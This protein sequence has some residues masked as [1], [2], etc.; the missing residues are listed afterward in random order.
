LDL[1][2]DL[3][4]Q[5][6]VHHL[7]LIGAYRDNEVDP[8]HPLIRKLEAIRMA[9]AVVHEVVLTPLPREALELLIRDALYCESEQA[10]ALASLIHEKT[11][12]NP[13]FA[14]QLITVLVE[15]ALLKFDYDEGQWSWDLDRIRAKGYTDNVVDLMVA[16]L[17]RLPAETQQALQLL[18]CMG[19]SAD[20]SLLEMA[21]RQ[22]IEEMHGPLWEAVR[23]GL[24]FRSEHAYTFLHDRIQEAAYLLIPEEARAEAHL[25]MGRLLAM[26]VAPEKLE[27]AIFEIVN[28]LNRA[29]PLI[30]SL[31]ER[32]S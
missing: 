21:S 32:E 2:E 11:A 29:A 16:Q 10:T 18:A 4:T 22:V 6:D 5:P 23:A 19:N 3:L 30:A 9:G 12:G 17:N 13:F 20:F 7:M 26:R 31:K 14:K 1:L 27:E 8:A 15:E 24:I 28:Q 25:E